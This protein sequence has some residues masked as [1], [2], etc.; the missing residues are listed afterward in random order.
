MAFASKLGGLLQLR[1]R[2]MPDEFAKGEPLESVLERYLMVVNRL[3]SA[4]R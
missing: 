3:R 4:T 2:L 1:E